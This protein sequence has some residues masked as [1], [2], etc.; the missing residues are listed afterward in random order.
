MNLKLLCCKP[1]ESDVRK[2][3][4]MSDNHIDIEIID[5][6]YHEKPEDLNLF[7]Q[8]KIGST[9]DWYDALLLCL[10]LC[11]KA[12]PNLA[13]KHMPVVVI[14]AHD[15]ITFSLGSREKFKEVF[16]K[17]TGTYYFTKGWLENINTESS[18]IFMLDEINRKNR[19][20]FLAEEYGEDNAEFLLEMETSWIGHYN[21]A[22]FIKDDYED[23]NTE[24]KKLEKITREAGWNLD[25]ETKEYNILNDFLSGNWHTNDFIV[26]D[27]G[28]EI[29]ETG[30]DNILGKRL[31]IP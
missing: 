24:I 3:A 2:I 1:M 7:L 11:S 25:F 27:P 12:T 20:K 22:L 16:N 19:L 28:E 26:L 13:A 21:R 31:K 10:G 6:K 14:K 18:A 17:N 5:I 15:C 29:F 4:D 9:D 23:N 30:D 8:E